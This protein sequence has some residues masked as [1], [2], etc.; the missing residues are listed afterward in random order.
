MTNVT[1]IHTQKQGHRP[2]FIEAWAELRGMKQHDLV[3]ELGVDKATV[4]RW[5][6]GSSPNS[7][8]QKMLCE[9]FQC[10]PEAIFRHPDDDWLSK[11]LRGR[12][13]EEIERIKRTLESAFPR[14]AANAN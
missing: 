3:R 13:Q 12:Q 7:H 11:F 1:H 10:E 4:S 8:W 6:S 9:F 5:Y 14:Q 2:H